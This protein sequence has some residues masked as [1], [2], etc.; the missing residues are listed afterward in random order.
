MEPSK[1]FQEFVLLYGLGMLSTF[2]LAIERSIACQTMPHHVSTKNG[3][4]V[5]TKNEDGISLTTFLDGWL[6][7]TSAQV[8]MQF[9]AKEK[10]N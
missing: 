3:A 8:C 1:S 2:Y 9:S 10:E 4:H 7:H 6:V 5:S